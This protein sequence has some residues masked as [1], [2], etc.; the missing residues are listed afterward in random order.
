MRTTKPTGYCHLLDDAT[1]YAIPSHVKKVSAVPLEQ[2][3]IRPART[4][5]LNHEGLVCPLFQF[6]CPPHADPVSMSF[7]IIL[8]IW[9]SML[10]FEHALSSKP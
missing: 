1:F 8:S 6:Q 3:S 7:S 4:S 9:F 2:G 5:F 10:K